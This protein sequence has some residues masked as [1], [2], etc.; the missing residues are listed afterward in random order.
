MIQSIAG[1]GNFSGNFVVSM[2]YAITTGSYGNI[3]V[4]IIK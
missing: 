4:V 2:S 3:Y 1:S